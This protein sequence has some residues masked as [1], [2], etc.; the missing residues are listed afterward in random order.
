LFHISCT[1]SNSVVWISF[2]FN[3][4]CFFSFDVSYSCLFNIMKRVGSLSAVHIVCILRWIIVIVA[5]IVGE[6][7]NF[8]AYA[9]APAILVTPLGALSI[10]IRQENIHLCLSYI[11]LFYNANFHFC[12][13]VLFLHMLCYR[14]S[15][16]FLGFSVVFFVSWVQ[17]QLF[18]MHLKNVRLSLWRKCG[19][20][21]QSQVYISLRNKKKVVR[22]L[23]N[24]FCCFPPPPPH[25]SHN[26]VILALWYLLQLFSCMLLLS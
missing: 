26:V 12:L 25:L 11:G 2:F 3:G 22:W 15:Y 14:K 6:I 16:T 17:H 1:F 4:I 23:I 18:S 7:A 5:V 13:A 20:L 8:A 9:F 10:I 21:Q 19:T 24:S